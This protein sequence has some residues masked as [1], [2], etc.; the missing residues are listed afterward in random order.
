MKVT[1][2]A[3]LWEVGSVNGSPRAVFG[4]DETNGNAT[5]ITI[6][7]ADCAEA[8]AV[9]AHIYKEFTVTFEVE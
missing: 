9:A 8:R 1:K 3:T 4:L 6:P 2:R 5:R 7:L